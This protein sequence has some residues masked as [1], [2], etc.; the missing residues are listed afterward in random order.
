MQLIRGKIYIS[1]AR[2]TYAKLDTGH[3]GYLARVGR[4]IC[5][6]KQIMLSLEKHSV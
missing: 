5:L 4:W 2:R 6:H 3:H 1:G